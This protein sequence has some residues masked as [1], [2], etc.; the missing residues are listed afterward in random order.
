MGIKCKALI[1]TKPQGMELGEINLPDMEDRDLL[2]KTEYSGVSVGTERWVLTGQRPDTTYPCITGYQNVGIVQDVGKKVEGF[3]PGDRV[4]LGVTRVSGLLTA[5]CHTSHC[6]FDY[7]KAVKLPSNIDPEE[8]TL[9]WLIGVSNL[10][11]NIVG[12]NAGDL[13]VVIG[14]GIVGQMAVQLAKIKGARVIAC[15]LID[16]RVEFSR[17]YSNA[18]IAINPRKE[19]LKKVV[20]NEKKEGADVVIEATGHTKLL[21]Q[22]ID[23]LRVRGRLSLGGYYP[24]KIT[25]TFDPPHFKQ[26][27]MFFPSGWGGVDGVREALRL[28]SEQKIKIKPLITHRIKSIEA[29]S[30]YDLILEKQEDVLG[31]IID[32]R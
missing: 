11:C 9:S 4:A 31:M 15:D 10:G 21:D 7:E 27:S 19:D 22:A 5:G 26:I 6:V 25:F 28:L 20:T 29:T 18:D 3:K 12:I 32:W 24:G 16:K 1:I 30:A 23:L 17:Q 14:Q 13:V 8:A 2:V